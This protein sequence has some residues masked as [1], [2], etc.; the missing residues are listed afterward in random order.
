MLETVV[1]RLGL[2][3]LL[4]LVLLGSLRADWD[5]SQISR[6][7]QALYGPLGPGQARIDAW[8]QLLATQQQGSELERLRQV[9]LFFN[10]QL[11][12]VEDIDLWRDVDYWA[13]PIQ[14]LIKGAGDCEDYAIA[15]YFSLRRMGI[16]S[17]K[18]RITYVKAL[19][20]NR[21]H[22]VLTYYSTPQAQPLVLDSLMDAIKPAG[23]RTD[24][25]PVYAFNGE[26]LWL[27]GAS[28]NKKVGDTKRLSRWQD[29]LKK[30]QAE[31]FPAEPVY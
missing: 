2:A 21:A 9:N 14:S 6:R 16:P 7:A 27:T 24:L 23:E 25:L 11:R 29:V 31:G 30:M 3:V 15:K 12:Y 10:Q 17:E 1:W 20:Q 18:L 5:F 28:G 22:M 19:R 13:T 26:G 4:A 8:Q